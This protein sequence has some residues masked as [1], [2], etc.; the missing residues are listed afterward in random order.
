MNTRIPALVLLIITP[1]A[2]SMERSAT[3][4]SP[5]AAYSPKIT[6]RED[7]LVDQAFKD[8]KKGARKNS[9]LSA[10][11]ISEL[12]KDWQEIASAVGEVSVESNIEELEVIGEET[13]HDGNAEQE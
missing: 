11:Q 10:R 9:S 2:Y 6:A 12:Q 3:P 8:L 13:T 5:H 7:F 1:I 4:K